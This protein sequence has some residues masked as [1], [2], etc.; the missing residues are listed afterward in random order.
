MTAGQLTQRGESNVDEATA[1]CALGEPQ[2]HSGRRGQH[3]LDRRKHVSRLCLVDGAPDAGIEPMRG[4]ES[5][6]GVRHDSYLMDRLRQ[7]RRSRHISLEQ[8]RA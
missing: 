2:M 7:F 3:Q 8:R 4:K 5:N 1:A 6:D